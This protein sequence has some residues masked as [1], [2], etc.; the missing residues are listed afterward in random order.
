LNK[1]GRENGLLSYEQVKNIAFV[2]DPFNI[3]SG[4]LTPTFKVNRFNAKKYF[5]KEI[6]E[7]YAA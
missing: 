3:E 4:V 6:Q 1:L 7:L 2:K 5:E